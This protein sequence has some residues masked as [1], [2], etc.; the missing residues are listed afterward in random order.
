MTKLEA[1]YMSSLVKVCQKFSGTSQIY[2]L[3]WYALVKAKAELACKFKLDKPYYYSDID[4]ESFC[5]Y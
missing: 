3:F 5:Y 1:L 4:R 2:S